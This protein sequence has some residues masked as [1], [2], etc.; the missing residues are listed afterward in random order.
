MNQEDKKAFDD[1]VDASAKKAVEVA[2]PAITA[3]VMK[4]LEAKQ[5]L[6][7]DIFGGGDSDKKELEESKK[8][9]AEYFKR[10]ALKQETKTLSPATS[11]AGAELVPT[12]VSDQFITVAQKYGLA[13]KYGTRW[14]MQGIN[15]NVPTL[16]AVQAYRMAAATT[17]IS[18]AQP[19]TGVVELRAKTV[20][21][22]VPISKILLENA[23][24]ALVDAITML[25]GKALAKLEDTWLFRGLGAG[26]GLFQNTGVPVFNLPSGKTTYAGATAEDLLSTEDLVDENFVSESMRWIMSLSVLNNF[27]RLRSV[28]GSDK[29]GFLFEAFGGNQP[30]TM[31]DIPFDTSAVMPKNSDV[32][33]AGKDFLGLVDYNNVIFG[34]NMEYRVEVSDQATI[35]DTNGETLINLFQQNMVALKVWGTIDIQLANPTLAHAI[36]AAAIS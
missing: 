2:T 14:P 30:A 6:R 25:T 9:A 17:P 26:E 19:T 29:Q 21:V 36:M 20:G 35:T 31:W 28:V 22:I 24:I 15:V 13:R 1:V 7:K 3:E 12:Y 11:T 18:S 5:P 16:S 34:D 33:Q 32:S 4:Q 8:V 10:K 23:S 27:R